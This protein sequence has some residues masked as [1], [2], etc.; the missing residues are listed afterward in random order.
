MAVLDAYTAR[1]AWGWGY[2]QARL[3]QLRFC[4]M[5]IMAWRT[6]LNSSDDVW[7]VLVEQKSK[8][9]ICKGSTL[10][11]TLTIPWRPGIEVIWVSSVSL[12]YGWR[13]IWSD[14]DEETRLKKVFLWCLNKLET[15]NFDRTY[16]EQILEAIG[17]PC[18]V[19]LWICT[20]VSMGHPRHSC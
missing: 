18:M 3:K 6:T 5:H 12:R 7:E 15:S 11:V 14:E 9:K 8:Y 17:W 1:R 19:W 2:F 16:I 10:L 13:K 4:Y 20:I